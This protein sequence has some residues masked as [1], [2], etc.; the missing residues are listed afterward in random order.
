MMD[1]PDGH[2]WQVLLGPFDITL[3]LVK[4]DGF[5]NSTPVRVAIDSIAGTYSSEA[6]A[7]VVEKMAT[8]MLSRAE[9]AAALSKVLGVKVISR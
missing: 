8:R 2:Y 1:A 6:A 9:K 4:T 3:E 7:Q 5:N